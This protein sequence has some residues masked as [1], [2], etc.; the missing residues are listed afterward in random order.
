MKAVCLLIPCM[1]YFNLESIISSVSSPN[2]SLRLVS[3]P[4]LSTISLSLP[5]TNSDVKRLSGPFS[6][7]SSPP[8]FSIT[9]P[10]IL[11]DRS[12]NEASSK[13]EALLQSSFLTVMSLFVK[14]SVLLWDHFAFLLRVIHPQKPFPLSYSSFFPSY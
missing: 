1:M 14:H 4:H 3:S 9:A 2:K 12:R 7:P 10:S 5:L 13:D 6:K 11:N 8:I